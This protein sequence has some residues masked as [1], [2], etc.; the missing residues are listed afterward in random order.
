M[1]IC[2]ADSAY[3]WTLPL[4]IPPHDGWGGGTPKPRKLNE[5]SA[6]I[7]APKPAVAMISQGGMTLGSM[8]CR[9]MWKVDA[10]VDSAAMMYSL[11]A[12]DKAWDRT[13][14]LNESIRG[15]EMATAVVI[16]P[17]PNAATTAMAKMRDGKACS[18]SANR[19]EIRSNMPP[20]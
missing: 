6:T 1:I 3:C 16:M 8:C 15:I 19:W 20:R 14:R 9:R 13:I 5:A 2:G 18:V 4:S 12:I 17:N 11:L 7:A 10:P